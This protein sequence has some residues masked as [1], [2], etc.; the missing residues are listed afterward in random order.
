MTKKIQRVTT[1][2]TLLYKRVKFLCTNTSSAAEKNIDLQLKHGTAVRL[3]RKVTELRLT[4]D[5]VLGL[6]P[7][8]LIEKYFSDNRVNSNNFTVQGVRGNITYLMPDFVTGRY[9]AYCNIKSHQIQ[10]SLTANRF[11]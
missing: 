2:A 9:V 11:A 1:N 8:E 5:E 4:L 3:K 6:T 7:S 10:L